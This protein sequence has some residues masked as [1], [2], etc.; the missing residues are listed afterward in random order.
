MLDAVQGASAHA[1]N[2]HALAKLFKVL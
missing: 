1:R 2:A